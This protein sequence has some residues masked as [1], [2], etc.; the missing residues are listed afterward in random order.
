MFCTF[1]SL[2]QVQKPRSIKR[3]MKAAQTFLLA[4]LLCRGANSAVHRHLR[5]GAG[6]SIGA[7]DDLETVECKFLKVDTQYETENGF[8]SQEEYRCELPPEAADG[9]E[10]LVVK[11]DGL[12]ASTVKSK[13]LKSGITNVKIKK[14]KG[15]AGRC[16]ST[17]SELEVLVESSLV[18]QST[19]SQRNGGDRHLE[20]ETHG[21]KTVLVLRVNTFDS[22][23]RFSKWELANGVFGSLVGGDDAH[24][25]ASQFDA[26][27]NG[28]LT[29]EPATGAGIQ[30][31]VMNVNI[32]LSSE[33]DNGDLENAATIVAEISGI[34]LSWFDHVMYCMPPS[35][36]SWIAYGYFDSGRTVYS[37]RFCISLSAQLHEFGHN[38]NLEHSGDGSVA[39]GD[40]SGYMGYSYLSSE[41]PLMCFNAAK[42]YQLGWYYDREVDLNTATGD[43]FS[44]KLVGTADYSS[45]TEDHTV[46]LR[47]Q[48]P[49]RNRDLFVMYNRA[50]GINAE[51]KTGKDK[52]VVS[53]GGNEHESNLLQSLGSNSQ[54]VI[55]DFEG[56]SRDLTIKTFGMG[57]DGS[58][59]FLNVLIGF[60]CSSSADCLDRQHCSNGV[61]ISAPSN[62]SQPDQMFRSPNV[63]P[64]D[65][66][67][68]KLTT[69]LDGA[70]A[71][72]GVM[73]D[74]EAKQDIS[75]SSLSIHSRYVGTLEVE[76]WT[77]TGS[78]Q[79]FSSNSDPWVKLQLE[80]NIAQSPGAGVVTPLPAFVQPITVAGGTQQAFYVSITNKLYGMLYSKSSS[81]QIGDKVKADQ[82]LKLKVG[83]A[84]SYPFG[85]SR[86]SRIWNGD[87]NYQVLPSGNNDV[88]FISP[89]I[90]QQSPELAPEPKQVGWQTL[91]FEDFENGWGEYSSG[92]NDVSLYN[93]ST[94]ARSGSK[95]ASIR[96]NTG[97]RASLG[98]RRSLDVSGHSKLRVS[99]WFINDVN[100]GYERDEEF[101][102]EFSSDVGTSW[103]RAQRWAFKN[104]DFRRKGKWYSD[105]VTIAAGQIS[106]LDLRFRSHAGN[107]QDVLYIDDIWIEGYV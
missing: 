7:D 55:S 6:A 16:N 24:N 61:C 76:V 14:G 82:N 86:A 67:W 12:D 41:G 15:L 28:Q 90:P 83:Y 107:N 33:S 89:P 36:Q 30:N 19:R 71:M 79:G 10:G 27:S 78:C 102:L 45:S 77:K 47:I 2:S 31:G 25:L 1:T 54:Y 66:I 88:V 92:G 65:N 58:V 105:T 37:D 44:G 39:Y 48:R 57:S 84:V 46:I 95:A 18:H 99:F 40:G 26:C 103:S 56:S 21:K 49:S 100:R 38:L 98:L 11:L 53:A 59:D 80:S 5:D 9:T 42:S 81:Y 74:V 51:T 70:Y 3:D 68:F 96:D 62:Q 23:N 91:S 32:D 69:D 106:N 72:D 101:F 29:F 63:T 93:G 75:I 20:S 104:G 17:E 97:E 94:Y 64:A 35:S 8:V 13:N 87:I 73:L 60:S 52:L 4:I 22:T 43:S 50:K 85:Y 34:K